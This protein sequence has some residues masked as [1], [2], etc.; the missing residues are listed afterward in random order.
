MKKVI[1][2]L[3]F[4]AVTSGI[5]AQPV[6]KAGWNTY[7]TGTITREYAYNFNNDTAKL[8]FIDSTLILTS[9]DSLVTMTL[10]YPPRDKSVY[11]TVHYFNEKKQILKTEEYKDENM[12]MS[13]EWRYDAKNRKEYYVEDNKVS[14]NNFR[15]TYDYFNDKKSGDNIVTETSYYNG[16]VEFYT[17]SYYDRKSVKYKEVRLNDNNKDVVHIET[18]YYGDNGKLKQRSV[19]FPEWKVTKKFDE[20][21]G[22]M[23]PKCAKCLP[24]GTA[25]KILLPTKV[26]FIKRL[27][28]RN[29]ALLSDPECDQFEYIFKNFTN[30]EIIVSTTNVNNAKKVLFRY[31]EKAY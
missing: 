30:C 27:L 1:F 26:A 5:V 23:Q 8:S 21:E 11:K 14:G 12:T 9:T 25:E 18:F 13:Y 17:K 4:L 2:I 28:G 19:Y 20:K 22:N 15:K 29:K 6:F 24:V 7:K 31:K 3:L 16:R 10:H